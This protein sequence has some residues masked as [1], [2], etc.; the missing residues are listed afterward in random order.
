MAVASEQAYAQDLP[1]SPD[2]V[3]AETGVRPERHFGRRANGIRASIMLQE[4]ATGNL[5]AVAPDTFVS[6]ARSAADHGAMEVAGDVARL[7]RAQEFAKSAA[8]NGGIS[9]ATWQT[10]DAVFDARRPDSIAVTSVEDMVRGYEFGT[11]FRRAFRQVD[12]A[13]SVSVAFERDLIDPGQ[14]MALV[15]STMFRNQAEACQQQA[16]RSSPDQVELGRTFTADE[17]TIFSQ[18]VRSL[19][20]SSFWSE[21]VAPGR[22]TEQQARELA[23]ASVQHGRLPLA[24]ASRLFQFAATHHGRLP[25]LENLSWAPAAMRREDSASAVTAE[26]VNAEF[27]LNLA[28][29]LALRAYDQVAADEAGMRIAPGSMAPHEPHPNWPAE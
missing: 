28:R 21:Q 18:Y 29:G 10:P 15:G 9:R 16:E 26:Y 23:S 13:Y 5:S 2:S 14:A 19:N 20:Q 24:Y 4:L 27:D 8:N 7:M 3:S 12:L 25:R 6:V 17:V 22:L 11:D 1:A